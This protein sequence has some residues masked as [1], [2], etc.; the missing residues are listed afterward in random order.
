[1]PDAL[2]YEDLRDDFL[3]CRKLGHA[4][5]SASASDLENPDRGCYWDV[6]SCSRCTARR[7]DLVSSGIGADERRRDEYLVGYE[8]GETVTRSQLRVE[9][10]QRLLLRERKQRRRNA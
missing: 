1:M 8:I 5:F 2:H 7:I 4:W 3:E 9:W 6:S 10:E